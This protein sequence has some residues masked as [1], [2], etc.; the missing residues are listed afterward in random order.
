MKF[1]G[2]IISS[3]YSNTTF[4]SR[5]VQNLEG[6]W[7]TV[8]LNCLV[9]HIHSSIPK[10][11][12]QLSIIHR[13]VHNEVYSLSAYYVSE[14]IVMVRIRELRSMSRRNKNTFILTDCVDYDKN[15]DIRRYRVHFCWHSMGWYGIICYFHSGTD[16]CVTR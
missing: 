5:A 14:V 15:V 16:W 1:L 3:P 9:N 2:F 11:Y 6:F 8:I 4:D 13:D 7:L 10:Y 12:V